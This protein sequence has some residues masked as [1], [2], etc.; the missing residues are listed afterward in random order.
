MPEPARVLIVDDDDSMRRVLSRVLRR[1]GLA[2]AEAAGGPEAIDLL[3]SGTVDV[4]I[5]DLV[6]P[7]MSGIQLLQLVKDRQPDTPV[8]LLTA[9]P[10]LATAVKAVEFGAFEYLTKPVDV[11]KLSASVVRAI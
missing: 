3:D 9:E 8:L 7:D 1:R 5:S 6:M 4:V 2:I 10:E 11:E